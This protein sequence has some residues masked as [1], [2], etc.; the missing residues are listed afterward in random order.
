MR[1]IVFLILAVFLSNALVSV[2]FGAETPY[3]L[4]LRG[5]GEAQPAHWGALARTVELAGLPKM[6]AGGSS[7]TISMFVLESMAAN[8]FVLNQNKTLQKERVSLMLKSLLGFVGMVQNSEEFRDFMALYGK[9]QAAKKTD[10][11]QTLQ[12]LIEK[13]NWSTAQGTIQ[14]AYK[15]GL[16]DTEYATLLLKATA[17]QDLKKSRFYLSELQETIRV[18]GSFNAASDQ[19]LFFRPG[20]ISFEKLAASFGR[21]AHFYST[22]GSDDAL[23][24]EWQAFFETCAPDSVGKSWIEL[25]TAKPVCGQMFAQLYTSHFTNNQPDIPMEEMQVGY[26]I[27]TLPTTSVLVKSAAAQALEAMKQYHTKLDPAFGASFQLKNTDDVRFGYWGNPE[28]LERIEKNLSARDEKSRRFYKLGTAQWK[29]VLSLSPAEPGLSRMKAFKN[30]G[31]TL[32]SA[33]GWSDLHPVLVL[34]A[35]GCENVIYVSRQGGDSIFGQG[36]AKRLLNL[37]RD[38]SVLETSTPEASKRNGL[39]NNQ[40]D[41]SDQTSLWSRL[42][43]LGNTSSSYNESLRQASAI[44]CTNW[45]DFDVKTQLVQLIE[46]SYRASFRVQSSVMNHLSPVLT[47]ERPGCQAP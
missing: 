20:V 32:V 35:A 12:D 38:W 3:C 17:E 44:L 21:V 1:T 18:F 10:L 26:V 40:G 28:T 23:K 14:R 9:I 13:K 45:N 16:I 22:L 31:E 36:V 29:E 4:A 19:N 42:Y 5:N 46:D 24:G 25:V 30:Q 8:P 15:L 39:L 27:P 6:M 7:A 34:K 33:G 41:R 2:A 11:S 47:E 43:N 37:D